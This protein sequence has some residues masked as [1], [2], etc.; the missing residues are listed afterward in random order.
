MLMEFAREVEATQLPDLRL[1][2]R[3]AKIV[4]ALS[5]APNRSIPEVMSSW[6]ATKATYAFLDNERVTHA[7]ILA[8]QQQATQERIAQYAAQGDQV[9]L[10]LQ[11]TTSFD[12]R[13][14]PATQELGP[15]E[16][17]YTQGFLVHTT[18]AARPNGV[19]LGVLEQQVW[20]RDAEQTGQA[21]K[22][23]ERPFQEKE[24][25]KWVQGL[26]D[27]DLALT[28]ITVCDREA[29]IYEFLD[30]ILTREQQVIVRASRGRSFTVEGLE[31]FDAVEQWSPQ[32]HHEVQLKRHPERAPRSAQVEVR[33]DTV[34]LKRPKRAN[35]ERETIAIQVVEV[36]EVNP[37]KGE[38][39]LHWVILT[40]LPVTSLEA[41]QQ[42]VTWY[43]N[44]WLIERF[45]YVLKSGCRLEERQLRSAA[46]LERFLAVC[47]QVAWRLLWLTYQAR[48]TPEASCEVALE[49]DEWQA[50]YATHHQT[51]QVPDTP[52]SLHEAVRW[53]ARLG[54]FLGRK[55]DGDPGVNVLWR[56]WQR[57]QDIVATWRLLQAP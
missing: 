43:S 29:H 22:R 13:H 18:L 24:S 38:A 26:P 52:P 57:L 39:A 15:L 54:G 40:T 51:Q 19:P 32:G 8:G 44:R 50:L 27:K 35:C 37:P 30:E 17:Q 14:H 31:L 1:K 42:I 56:G 12:Y 20:T 48:I 45:H 7:A 21:Q 46:R 5:T 3:L 10:L 28:P 11:D 55:S 34:T 4:D 9:V 49:R 25:Y 16:N 23:H 36:R 33:Y 53:I 2:K 41:S 6:A 47:N